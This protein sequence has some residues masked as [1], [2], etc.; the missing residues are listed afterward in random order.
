VADRVT[1][2]SGKS[3]DKDFTAKV[4]SNEEEFTAEGAPAVSNVEPEVR[5]G[6]RK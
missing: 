2:I 4:R 3:T 5:K 1:E 6:Q